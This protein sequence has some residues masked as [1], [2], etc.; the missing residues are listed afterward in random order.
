MMHEVSSKFHQF[1]TAASM[2]VA[3]TAPQILVGLGIFVAVWVVALVVKACIVRIGRRSKRHPYLYRLI[4]ST[5]KVAILIAGLV[6]ALGT[7]GINV[8]ALVAS[9]GLAGF[10]IGFALKDT[11]SNLLAGFMVL[12]YQPFK[13]G[14]YIATDKVEGQVID[15]NLRYTVV[16]TDTQHTYVPNATVISNPV[17]VKD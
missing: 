5:V 10:A 2:E 9:L 8:S 1:Y 13:P 15:I 11:L 4:G 6:T 14:D 3:K 12:F 7:M 17:T 16:K